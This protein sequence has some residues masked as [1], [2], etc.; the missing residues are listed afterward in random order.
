MDKDALSFAAGIKLV[1][2]G[3]GIAAVDVEDSTAAKDLSWDRFVRLKA[4]AAAVLET[5]AEAILDV[6]GYD[7]ALAFFLP[8][9]AIDLVDPAS[10]G[11]SILD[12]P[13]SDRSYATVAAVDVLEH[14]DTRDRTRAL[15]ELARVASSF[16]ILNYPS[17]ESKD[18][19]ELIFEL[20]GN[21]LVKEH[22]QWE[23]PDTDELLHEMN[24]YG[25]Q[26]TVIPHAS[27]AVWLG[28]YVTLNMV[29]EAAKKLNR[30]LVENYAEEPASRCLYHLV[31][32]RRF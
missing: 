17:R 2:K 31:I 16:V 14:I 26:G 29:P 18:A 9:V 21:P 19:Q 27:I 15:G 6:G 10:T 3:Q 7:G 30:H 11:G 28:Q 5:R 13:A 23:L 32:C 25:F 8:G 20:T 4:A 24:N 1:P 12:I 22:V